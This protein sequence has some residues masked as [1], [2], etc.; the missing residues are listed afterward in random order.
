MKQHLVGEVI[1]IGDE[2]TSGARVDTNAAWLSRRLGELGIHVAFHSTVGDT[3]EHNVDVFRIASER[4]DVVVCTGGLG[5]TRDDLTRDALAGLTNQPL[6]M[7]AASL[8]R[9][10]SMFRRRKREMPERNHVQALFPR[11]SREIINPQGTAPG[12]DLVI[13]RKDRNGCHLYALPG[14][15]AEMKRMFDETVAAR[16]LGLSGDSGKIHHHVM[17]FFGTGESDMEDRLGDMISRERQP[18]VGI[19][20][21]A[22]TISLRITAKAETDDQC[23]QM[24]QDT[25][26][27][28]LRLVSEFH[29]GDGEYFEQQHAINKLLQDHHQ[30]LMVIEFGRAAL[31]GDWFAEL[32]PTKGYQGGLSLSTPTDLARMFQAENERDSIDR[33]K[34]AINADW[35]LVVD[36]YPEL[37]HGSDVPLAARDVRMLIVNPEGR[38]FT[39]TATLGGHPSIMQP[40]IA[41]TAMASLRKHLG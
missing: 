34:Y 8:Q 12:I 24:I 26:T 7:D 4:S 22:A 18:R 21:T 37:A 31:L 11:G 38:H 33:A 23:D 3:L 14:V 20:V 10:E 17:K 25:R 6:E 13:E 29:F 39:T 40:R 30:S 19:T 16:I 27:E 5:P 36:S 41:K 35:A 28:I 2:M 32:G 1:S 15:P 9:I